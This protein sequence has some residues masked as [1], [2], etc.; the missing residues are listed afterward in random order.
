MEGSFAAM[1]MMIKGKPGEKWPVEPWNQRQ[2][3]K[4]RNIKEGGQ[5]E[6]GRRVLGPSAIKK[7]IYHR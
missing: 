6:D 5:E 1:E 2:K 4:K 7:E 3:K